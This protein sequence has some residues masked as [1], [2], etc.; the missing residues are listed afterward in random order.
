MLTSCY[1]IESTGVYWVPVYSILE[2]SIPVIVANA[3]KIKHIPGR[4]TDARDSEWIAE[5]CLNGL[6][7]PS[8][9][10]YFQEKIES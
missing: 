7:E 5:L 10:L 8:R 9:I 6:I 3:H 1:K 4:K 2:G